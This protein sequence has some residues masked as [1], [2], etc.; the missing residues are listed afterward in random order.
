MLRNA[1]RTELSTID[2]VE[3]ARSFWRRMKLH[4]AV[5]LG[6][7]TFQQFGQSFAPFDAHG[8]IPDNTVNAD[9]ARVFGDGKAA[10]LLRA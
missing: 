10:T 9:E 4:E 3:T 2:T 8:A 7:K 1:G 6:N 5:L